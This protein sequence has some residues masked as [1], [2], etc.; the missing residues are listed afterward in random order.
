[1]DIGDCLVVATGPAPELS[2]VAAVEA[3][4]VPYALAGD[5]NQPGDFLS[6][7][8]DAWMVALLVLAVA[9]RGTARAGAAWP[10]AAGFKAFPLVLLPLELAR[11]RFRQPRR[12]WL[13]LKIHCP[14]RLGLATEEISAGKTG[15]D[16][17]RTGLEA[18][19][20]RKRE[21]RSASSYGACSYSQRRPALMVILRVSLMSSWKNME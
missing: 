14:L 21:R 10:L 8:R 2:A 19:R 7:L 6:C 17:W 16:A 13:S 15:A 9:M 3:A 11:T 4:G 20:S 5:C 12:F 18:P 1:M